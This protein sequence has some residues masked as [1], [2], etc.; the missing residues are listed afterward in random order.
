MKALSRVFRSLFGWVS[1][2]QCLTGGLVFWVPDVFLQLLRGEEF[3]H[4][5]V[6][7]LTIL[8]P[9]ATVASYLLQPV[10]VDKGAMIQAASSLLGV[11]LVAPWAL[12][13]AATFTGGGFSHPGDVLVSMSVIIMSTIIPI[14]T[15]ILA[16]Y[17][18]SLLAILLV[19]LALPAVGA[20][21]ALFNHYVLRGA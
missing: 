14:Y 4:V 10:R 12:T 3:G 8:M 6:K 19:T 15:V 1:L 9:T 7:L 18:G 17:D 13:T 11:W 16:T 20:C 21:R 2:P 5:D